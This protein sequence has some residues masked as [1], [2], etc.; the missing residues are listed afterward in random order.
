MPDRDD[1]AAQRPPSPDD[2]GRDAV[3]HRRGLPGQ[4]LPLTDGRRGA[5]RPARRRRPRGPGR[6]GQRR[7]RRLARRRADGPRGPPCS[8][9]RVRRDAGT[10]RSSSAPTG[11]SE[12]DLVLAMD[13]ANHADIVGAGS[14]RPAVR[15]FRDFDPRASTRTATCPTPTSA[16]T[17]A[18]RRCSRWS[19]A[20]RTRWS[21]PWPVGC[22]ARGR[23]LTWRGW[24]GPRTGRRRCSA[25]RSSP[26]PPSPAATS[27]PPPGCGSPTAPRR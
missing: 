13:A 1:R 12:L 24:A 17:T 14:A 7:H 27:A 19:S 5:Q 2:T 15:M 22:T 11:S 23:A 9:A 20:P 21:P 8:H 10:A 16:A 4:H 3:P 6:G 26:P 18:S 25:P